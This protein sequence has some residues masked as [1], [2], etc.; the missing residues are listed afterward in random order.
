MTTVAVERLLYC[1][2][3]NL[4]VCLK[5]EW[6]ARASKHTKC[7][8][9]VNHHI[10]HSSGIQLTRHFF[11]CHLIFYFPV[12]TSP[13]IYFLLGLFLLSGDICQGEKILILLPVSGPSHHNVF[14]PIIK[15]LAEKGHDIVSI[16][17]VKS[18]NLPPNVRQLQPLT[19][20]DITSDMPEP[21]AERR[22]SV[23][24]RLG[25]DT[26][27]F[28]NRACEKVFKNQEIQD[29]IKNE[30]YFD[31]VLIDIYTNFCMLGLI[32]HFKASSI[33][34]STIPAPTWL[35]QILGNRMPTS[36]VPTGMIPYSDRMSL[37]E[38]AISTAMESIM[39]NMW[40]SHVLK[41]GEALYRKYIPEGEK[42]P[43]IS[44]I[45]ANVSMIFMNSH[46]AITHPRPLFPSII[47]IG[48]IHTRPAKQ[49]PKV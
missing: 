36:F 32:P 37:K 8:S 12:M 35:T 25:A 46:F 10:N 45:S 16:S 4:V 34:V 18:P 9:D 33:Y 43:S 31:L 20:K 5:L 11:S 19:Y 3:Y 41:P 27:G 38:R 1:D 24:E 49:L 14:L 17:P 13:K 15:S 6:I 29:L 7:I 47:E 2:S 26:L 28:I 42:L 44:E 39:E 48:G 30:K 23:Y 21:I 22:K 40:I